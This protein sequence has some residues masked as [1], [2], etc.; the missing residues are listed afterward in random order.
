NQISDITALSGLT[1]LESL[2]LQHNQI[3]DISALSALTN[4]DYLYVPFNQISDISAV[5]G[6]TNLWYLNLR[7][8]QISD[9]SAVAGLTNLWYLYLQANPL[10]QDA[11]D[12][13]IPQILQNNPG[14][15][16]YYD[17]CPEPPDEPPAEKFQVGEIVRTTTALRVRDDNMNKMFWGKEKQTQFLPFGIVGQVTDGPRVEKL[18]DGQEYTFWKI[19]WLWNAYG[20]PVEGWS[21]E[22]YSGEDWLVAVPSSEDKAY[23]LARMIMSEAGQYGELAQRAVGWTAKNRKKSPLFKDDIYDVV[24]QWAHYSLREE[25]TDEGIRK[26]AERILAD[27]VTDP[28]DGA[29][30]FFSPQSMKEEDGYG[31]YPV[32]EENLWKAY[33]P[34][35]AEPKDGWG[36]LSSNL[37]SYVTTVRDNLQWRLLEG[38]RPWYFMFYRP[39]TLQISASIQSP[40]E[41][42]VYDSEGRLTGVVNGTVV[43]EIPGSECFNNTIVI[44]FPRGL[45]QY[46]VAGTFEGVYGLTVTAVTRQE[47]IT[48]VA[49]EIP[50]STNVIHQYTIDW[51]S[52][53]QGQEGVTLQIDGDGDGE[54]EQSIITGPTLE[55]PVSVDEYTETNLGRVGYDRRTRRFSVNAT[56]T[57]TSDT[58]IGSPVWLVIESISNPGVTLANADGTTIDGK[59]YIDLSGLLG[60]GQLEPG[61]SVTKRLYFNNPNR[62]RFTFEP[63]IRGVILEGPE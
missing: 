38:I 10:N 37:T 27:E 15:W 56:V 13:Y 6:L 61:E 58:A 3:S 54:F 29:D 48:F 46:Q 25:P 36:A 21:A 51:D 49:I 42:R 55:A 62:V 50:T 1:N 33:Y 7:N 19:N 9:I 11:C 59:E 26:L 20:E 45:Y 52:L 34:L 18:D 57:N 41:L 14:I 8:N 40:G 5:V 17:P 2:S 32:P 43:S 31:P 23:W 28:T 4:L 63:S 60:D 35:W 39:Y 24:T 47:D 16:L 12:I 53:S 30:H 44:H 22:G